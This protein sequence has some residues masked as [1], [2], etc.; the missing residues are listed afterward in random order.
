MSVIDYG[1]LEI[2]VVYLSS[3]KGCFR[4]YDFMNER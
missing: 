1:M 4:K 3:I 2:K